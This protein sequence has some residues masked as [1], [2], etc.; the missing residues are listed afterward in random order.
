MKFI[1][2]RHNFYHLS[3]IYKSSRSPPAM[4]RDAAEYFACV[5]P[6]GS[7]CGRRRGHPNSVA[8][9]QRGGGGAREPPSLLVAA[10]RT[11]PLGGPSPWLRLPWRTKPQRP[12]HH[13]SRHRQKV[14]A[15]ASGGLLPRRPRPVI[16]RLVVSGRA[17]PTL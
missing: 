4:F 3:S 17:I 12:A 5:A 15:D 2:K 6:P 9:V 10:N 13:Q 7:A 8:R 1:H 11:M 14:K 16:H